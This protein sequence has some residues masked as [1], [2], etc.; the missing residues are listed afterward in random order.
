MMKIVSLRNALAQHATSTARRCMATQAVS[1]H[2]HHGVRSVRRGHRACIRSDC[3]ISLCVC[4]CVLSRRQSAKKTKLLINGQFI[5]SRAT[6]W[7][8]V[9]NP[10]SHSTREMEEV[11]PDGGTDGG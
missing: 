1:H 11:R 3:A 2:T 8:P 10:V 5:E 6:E 9:K 7:M 4:L